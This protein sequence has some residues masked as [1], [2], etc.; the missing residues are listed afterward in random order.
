ML[1]RT[2]IVFL[3]GLTDQNEFSPRRLTVWNT[4][5]N[6]VLCTTFHFTSKINIV[7]VNQERMIVCDA[8]HMHIY[9]INSME[10]IHTLDCGTIFLGKIAISPN[11]KNN[12]VCFTSNKDE[13]NV[14]IFDLKFLN[15]KNPPIK[16]HKSPLLRMNINFK[17]DMLVTCSCHGTMIRVFNLP[18]GYLMTSYQIGI[19]SAYIF[20][21]GFSLENDE[22]LICTTDTGFIHVLN[23]EKSTEE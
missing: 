16:A 17:G 11:D 3:V 20:W 13:G 19:N 23:I 6:K 5:K 12:I 8:S 1:F 15:F 22:K 7:K 9:K 2:N 18:K 4:I 21:M 14:K 10:L